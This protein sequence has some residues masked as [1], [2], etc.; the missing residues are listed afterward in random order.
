MEENRLVKSSKTC[1]RDVIGKYRTSF[2]VN[3]PIGLRIF[4]IFY[5]I[6]D[7]PN[8]LGLLKIYT[9]IKNYYYCNNFFGA[10]RL[11]KIKDKLM[12]HQIS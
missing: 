9:H 8:N 11:V 6:G 1:R 3:R 2:T 10:F 5:S 7:I 4:I 12:S